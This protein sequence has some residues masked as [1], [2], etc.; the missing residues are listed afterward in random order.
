MDVLFAM[1]SFKLFTFNLADFFFLNDYNVQRKVG[2]LGINLIKLDGYSD[3]KVYVLLARSFFLS[4][5]FGKK[6]NWLLLKYETTIA[7]KATTLNV[8]L[9]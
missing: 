6:E 2:K 8:A 9:N 3:Y 7:K 5:I 1:I 4:H